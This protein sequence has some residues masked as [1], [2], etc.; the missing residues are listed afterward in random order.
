MLQ[1]WTSYIRKIIIFSFLL[2]LINNV[3]NFSFSFLFFF[4]FFFLSFFLHNIIVPILIYFNDYSI[5]F[6]SSFSFECWVLIGSLRS[7]VFCCC[8]FIVLF[9]LFI[10][11]SLF[12]VFIFCFVLF[13]CFFFVFFVY[14]IVLFVCL[15]V[16]SGELIKIRKSFFLRLKIFLDPIT[17]NPASTSRSFWR[18]HAFQ[19]FK[20]IMFF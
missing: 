11:F 9:F 7:T 17:N 5:I 13:W 2:K 10:C 4:F 1:S 8:F 15:F 19:P 6:F 3:K 14:C 20:C 16:F 18:D 12:C